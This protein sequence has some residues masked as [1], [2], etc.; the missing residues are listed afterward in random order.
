MTDNHGIIVCEVCGREPL[1]NTLKFR[2]IW[3]GK[4]RY[5]CSTHC[6]NT[7][8]HNKDE[9]KGGDQSYQ[10]AERRSR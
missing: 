7:W 2:S 3:R 9:R 8:D 4:D 1:T 5:F 10:G 6:I